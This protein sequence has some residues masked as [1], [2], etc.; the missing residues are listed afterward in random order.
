MSPVLVSDTLPCPVGFT[1]TPPNCVTNKPLPEHKDTPIDS[2]FLISESGLPLG[3]CE[4]AAG[5]LVSADQIGVSVNGSRFYL[6][7]LTGTQSADLC[8]SGKNT[9]T[10]KIK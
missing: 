8:T 9:V 10:W 7:P 4:A 3:A 1:G 2:S 5:Y 6:F